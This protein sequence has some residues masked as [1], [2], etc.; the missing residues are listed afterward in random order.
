MA[1]TD[2]PSL[3]PQS[4]GNPYEVLLMTGNRPAQ[5]AL[6]EALETEIVGLPQ[7]E[8]AFDVSHSAEQELGQVTKYARCIVMVRADKELYSQTKIKYEKNVYAKPQVIVYVNTPSYSRLIADMPKVASRLTELLNRFEMNTEIKRLKLAHN[9]KAEK[10]VSKMLGCKIWIPT[11][12]KSMKQGKNFIWLSNN[13][14]S[15]MQNICIYTY[16]GNSL[17]INEIATKRDSVM[18]RNIPGEEPEMYMSTEKKYP[19]NNR[20]LNEKGLRIVESRGL[21]TI[22]GDAMGGPFVSHSITDSANGRI[23]VAEGFVYSPDTKKRNK[24]KQLEA[25]LYTLSLTK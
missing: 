19:L 3:L 23:I 25:A 2:K 7:A 13:T 4:G 6:T 12:M 24:M 20:I 10:A 18:K 5:Q 17:N 21:W 8:S 15:G 1:C 14:A 9:L 16:A 22:E 11:D